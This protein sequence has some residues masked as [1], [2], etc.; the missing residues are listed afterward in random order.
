MVEI[1]QVDSSFTR[2]PMNVLRRLQAEA[3]VSRVVMWDS[4][5]VWLV[6]RYVEAKALLIGK[7]EGKQQGKQEAK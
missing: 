3:P 4:V 6:T 2:D 1:P 5:P 7:Q